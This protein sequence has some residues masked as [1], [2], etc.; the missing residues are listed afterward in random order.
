VIILLVLALGL[1][2]ILK[3]LRVPAA[4][5]IG[6]MVVSAIGHLSAS[7]PGVLSPSIAQGT[8]VIMGTLIGT[9]FSGISISKLRQSLTAGLATTT[10]TVG[11]AVVAA[12]PAAAFLGMPVAHVLIAFAPG[13]LETMIVM[14][15]VLGANPGFVAASH[16]GR[17]LLLTV[18]VPAV[19]SRTP[20]PGRDQVG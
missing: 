10:L 1:G 19:L 15:A 11:L 3:R 8:L 4:L 18:L 7:S 13:G 6:A 2:L 14:G 9:R 20:K 16:V 12:T 17:L 5:L